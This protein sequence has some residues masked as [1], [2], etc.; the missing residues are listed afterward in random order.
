MHTAGPWA[1]D[2]R[3][4][5]EVQTADGK[6]VAS[7]WHEY[8]DGQEIRVTG[9]LCCSIEESAANARLIAAAPELLEALTNLLAVVRGEGGTKPDDHGLADRAIA[10]A[11]G[12]GA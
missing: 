11:T 10:K 9:A 8:A 12:A 6:T 5:S 7:C 3:Y 4:L 1:V 2:A